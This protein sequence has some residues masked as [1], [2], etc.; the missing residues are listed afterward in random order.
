MKKIEGGSNSLYLPPLIRPCEQYFAIS[1]AVKDNADKDTFWGM[2]L[3]LEGDD[4]RIWMDI[5]QITMWH[6]LCTQKSLLSSSFFFRFFKM[7]RL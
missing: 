2:K 5:A 3:K 4:P 6:K 1:E 7:D